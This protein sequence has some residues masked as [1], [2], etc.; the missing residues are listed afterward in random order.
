MGIRYGLVGTGFWAEIV[1]AAAAA[2]HPGI[3]FV[4]IF[5]RNSTRTAALADRF[6]VKSFATLDDLLGQVDAIAVAVPPDFQVDVVLRAAAAGKHVL[7]EKPIAPNATDAG[8][9]EDAI[10]KAGVASINLLT[11]RFIDSN[12]QWFDSVQA[13]GGWDCGRAEFVMPTLVT[14]NPFANSPWRHERGALWD[15]GPHA[16]SV[17]MGILGK[18][19][20]VSAIQGTRDQTHALFVHED[21]K[22][23][24]LSLTMSAP[25]SATASTVYIYGE[26]GRRLMPALGDNPRASFRNAMSNAI[27][28]LIVQINTGRIGHPC[29]VHFGSRI[30]DVLQAIEDAIQ[31][32]R[33]ESVR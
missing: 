6:G 31:S 7:L 33:L 2:T 13:E 11:Y 29:D 23:S 16:L 9:I 32:K 5:G 1:H 3:E 4:G 27:D 25:A 20:A 12:K 26:H 14:D 8:R 28:A 19:T 30:V 24:T 10:A 21:G 22:S 17:L 18:V 15:L